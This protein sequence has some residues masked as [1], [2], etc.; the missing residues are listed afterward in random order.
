[1]CHR[2]LEDARLFDVLQ[3]FDEDLA[4]E[5]RAGRCP[6]CGGRLDVANYPRK[7]RGGPAG[8]DE[9][10][11][12][13]CAEEGCRRRTTP[14]SVRFLGRKVYLGA[15]VVLATAM[16]QGLSPPRLLH[17]QELLGVSRRT[18]KRWRIF[19]AELFGKSPFWQSAR[20]RLARPIEGDRLPLGLL[21]VMGWKEVMQ[22]VALLRLLRFITPITTR[23]HLRSQ[24]I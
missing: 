12:F 24:A 2:L 13:C 20:G 6:F 10:L 3:R 7:P 8:H 19:W 1:L 23:P 16:Q 5:T 15:M 11:S 18:L 22:R 4:A 21:E 14:P 17:L 9:R